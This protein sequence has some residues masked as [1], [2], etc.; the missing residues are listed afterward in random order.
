MSLISNGAI[1]GNVKFLTLKRTTIVPFAHCTLKNR[2]HSDFQSM[3]PPLL[4]AP[5][6]RASL[7]L[8]VRGGDRM[9]K[10]GWIGAL[11]FF[12]LLA[13]A[14]VAAAAQPSCDETAVASAKAAI[15]AD[16]PCA[17]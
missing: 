11:S 5:S 6:R 16:C 13:L 1:F 15:D 4:L 7:R 14:G 8:P 17:G 9:K 12:T 10:T 2:R 3:V